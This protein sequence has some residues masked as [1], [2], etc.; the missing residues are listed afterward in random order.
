MVH[1][2][3]LEAARELYGLSPSEDVPE[4]ALNKTLGTNPHGTL[5]SV[6]QVAH[7]VL[8]NV[9]VVFFCNGVITVRLCL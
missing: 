5:S 4:D 9:Q 1:Q 2:K 8:K 6:V 7:S 3:K